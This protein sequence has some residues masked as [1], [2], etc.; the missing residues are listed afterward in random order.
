MEEKHTDCFVISVMSYEDIRRKG[1]VEGRN[2][3]GKS[4]YVFPD[5][6]FW[7]KAPLGNLISTAL[8]LYHGTVNANLAAKEENYNFFTSYVRSSERYHEVLVRRY[9]QNG[10][11][12]IIAS[13][14]KSDL[15]EDRGVKDAVRIN[16]T[17]YTDEPYYYVSILRGALYAVNHNNSVDL[18]GSN[19]EIWSRLA[20]PI[21]ATEENEWQ[22]DDC[23][24]INLYAHGR[25]AQALCFEYYHCINDKVIMF[26]QEKAENRA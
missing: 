3:V 26:N 1:R 21:E 25:T 19:E 5:D 2:V 22:S 24:Y 18:K 4:E 14:K 6:P 23:Q 15:K 16:I 13:I 11:P 7:R 9:D 12:D 17:M 20:P 8:S 10:D